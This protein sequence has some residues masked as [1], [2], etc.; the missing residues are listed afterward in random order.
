MCIRDS[1]T[2]AQRQTLLRDSDKDGEQSAGVLPCSLANVLHSVS[3]SQLKA[4]QRARG[5]FTSQFQV[6]NGWTP[7]SAIK[8][9]RKSFTLV[10]VGPV[11]TESPSA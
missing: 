9:A 6:K 5:Q 4:E 10:S 8:M 3:A 11:T 1:L 7:G 2:A